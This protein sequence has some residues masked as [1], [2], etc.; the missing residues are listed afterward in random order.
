M[1]FSTLKTRERALTAVKRPDGEMVDLG[2]LAARIFDGFPEVD[3]PVGV[4]LIEAWES[5]NELVR[6]TATA[7]VEKNSSEL[8]LLGPESF[9]YLPVVPDARQVLAV[10]LNY[11]DHCREQGL[12]PP[13]SPIFFVKL[14]SCL[15]GHRE[16]IVLWPITKQLD[17][18]GELAVIIGKGGRGI[19]EAKALDHCFGYTVMN[20]VTARE[21]QK[22]D[23]QWI[24][25]KGL[26]T[27]G[28]M[29]PVAV[30]RDEIPDPQGLRIRTWVNGDLRQDGSTAEMV[31]G[32]A[33]IVSY[34][35]EAITLR[36]GDVITT[37]TPSG[38]G[39]FADPPHFLK[40]NDVVRIEITNIGVL[41]NTVESTSR[42]D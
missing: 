32:V 26:D 21:I 41:E 33:R 19:P 4:D 7:A 42:F 18:E 14:P 25:G 1:R 40:P 30:T 2:A 39:V 36:P 27:F 28:P 20:D 8:P 5:E 6:T 23:R 22:D 37:G 9:R 31:A 13:K 12:T 11:M 24:R 35:S 38:V 16:P 10:G 34:A 15:T 3:F 29:G 17:F